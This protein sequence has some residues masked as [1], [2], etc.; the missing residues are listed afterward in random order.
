MMRTV[1]R[2]AAA[3]TAAVALVSASASA[4]AEPIEPIPVAVE[5]GSAAVDS[6]SAAAQSAVWLF[7]QG[8]VIGFLVLLG[9]TPFQVLTGGICDLAT[10]SAL[11][12][13][14]RAEAY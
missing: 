5:S 3:S 9:V 1:F 11:P 8:N 4:V 13:P 14:C 7:Q 2:F 6:G 12:N 10:M